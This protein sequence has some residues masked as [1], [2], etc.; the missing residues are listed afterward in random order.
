MTEKKRRFN[1]LLLVPPLAFLGLAGAFYAGLNRES[2]DELPSA[3]AGRTAP[4]IA[5]P[6]IEGADWPAPSDDML[7]A[8]GVKLVNFWASWCAPCRIEHPLLMQLADSGVTIIGVNYKDQPA[9]AR[10]F[11]DELGNPYTAVGADTTGRKGID[12]GLYGVPE[13]FVIDA[14]GKVLLRYPGPVTPEIFE[15]RFAPLL[16]E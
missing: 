7:T 8:E 5:L 14:E 12:W 1:W 6:P 3:F 9:A 13:T 4:A 15:R 2:P 10:G 11:L 16:T